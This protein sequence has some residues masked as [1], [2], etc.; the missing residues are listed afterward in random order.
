MPILRVMQDFAPIG[1]IG[2]I[3]A[4]TGKRQD[5]SQRGAAKKTAEKAKTLSSDS[6]EEYFPTPFEE[7]TAA[8]V[9]AL[10]RLRAT[11]ALSPSEETT[12]RLLR[13]VKY[14][15]NHPSTPPEETE[16]DAIVKPE[17]SP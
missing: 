9:E 12:R 11:G 5:R 16:A 2:G 8:L 15:H 1:G 13:G 4:D 10:D 17:G 7:P 14:Y 6:G 3:P